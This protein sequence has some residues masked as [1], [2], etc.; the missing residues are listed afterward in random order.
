MFWDLFPGNWQAQQL[1]HATRFVPARKLLRMS[2]QGRD[3]DQNPALAVAIGKILVYDMMHLGGPLRLVV[4]FGGGALL[5]AGAV[6]AR[7][8]LP[9]AGE[10]A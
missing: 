10:S 2:Y 9:I 3:L 4:L 7:K 6:L 1:A 5:F 8:S